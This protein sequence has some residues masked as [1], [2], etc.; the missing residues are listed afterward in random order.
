VKKS[1]FSEEKIIAVLKQAEAGVKAQELCRKHGISQATLYNWKAKYGGM[2]PSQLKRLKELEA[3]H[4]RLKRMYADLSL[5]HHAL[6]DAVQ[7]KL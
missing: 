1:R 2:E 6:Q 5:T 7:K 4:N 3:E